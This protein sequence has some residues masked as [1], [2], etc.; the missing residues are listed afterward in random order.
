MA[1]RIVT[2][3]E[4]IKRAGFKL[5]KA[6]QMTADIAEESVRSLT[7][8]L[9]GKLRRSWRQRK[10]GRKEIDIINDLP[11]VKVIEYGQKARAR[12]LIKR[13]KNKGKY[14]VARAK[15]DPHYMVTKTTNNARRIADIV[16]AELRDQ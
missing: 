12:K 2:V 15:Q 7:P 9:T 16:A 8:V 1:D 5:E 13:G 3:D 14:K 10:E 4:A 11:Y 6:I